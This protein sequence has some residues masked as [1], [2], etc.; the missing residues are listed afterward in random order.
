MA[1]GTG[2]GEVDSDR[3]AE[4]SEFFLV[5]SFF[6][7]RKMYERILLYIFLSQRKKQE[8]KNT[9]TKQNKTKQNKTTKHLTFLTAG[10]RLGGLV[11]AYTIPPSPVLT[12]SSRYLKNVSSV[13]N[14]PMIRPTNTRQDMGRVNRYHLLLAPY[15][16]L[17]E[18]SVRKGQR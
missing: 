4:K 1:E 10:L 5:F 9:H 7:L 17:Q 8:T 18:V 13:K 12:V 11:R 15:C 6:W 14:S 3:L 16:R 2:I